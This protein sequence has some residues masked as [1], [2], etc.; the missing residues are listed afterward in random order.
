MRLLLL[1]TV[2]PIA[3][4]ANAWRIVTTGLLYR[5]V[6]GEAAQRFGHDVAGWAMILLA[7]GLFALV[8]WYFKSLFRATEV[9]DIGDVLRREQA[10]A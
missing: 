8:L 1:T 3:L 5:Y 2:I 9:P 4:V 6:S 7:A 10:E